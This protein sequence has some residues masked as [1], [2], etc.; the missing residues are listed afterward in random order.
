L[1]DTIKMECVERYVSKQFDALS[2]L[3]IMRAN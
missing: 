2:P 1:A 3:M